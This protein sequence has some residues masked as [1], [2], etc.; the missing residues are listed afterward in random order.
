MI[1][2]Y[3]CQLVLIILLV[4]FRIRNGCS[5]LNHYE[6][7]YL[8]VNLMQLVYCQ[9]VSLLL[10]AVDIPHLLKLSSKAIDSLLKH[11]LFYC[12][13]VVFFLLLVKYNTYSFHLYI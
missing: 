7:H 5:V 12:L 10:V 4:L 13:Q 8:K 3:F 11:K 2:K 1:W 9:V 6:H